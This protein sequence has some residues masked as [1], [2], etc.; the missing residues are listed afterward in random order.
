MRIDD[1][2]GIAI[3]AQFEAI[4]AADGRAIQQGVHHYR[5]AFIQRRFEPEGAKIRKFFA[6][7]HAGV[8]R[9]APRGHPHLPL[10]RNGAEVAGALEGRPGFAR[11]PIAHATRAL[12]PKSGNAGLPCRHLPQRAVCR[13]GEI[14]WPILDFPRAVAIDYMHGHGLFEIFAERAKS[15]GIHRAGFPP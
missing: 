1:H 11:M 9:D 13:H 15:N 14:I 8:D 7:R 4:G 2:F 5:I 12:H 3:E 6:L 10:P